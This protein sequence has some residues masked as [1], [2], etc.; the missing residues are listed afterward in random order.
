MAS[1]YG[2]SILNIAAT[3]AANG[4]IGC[5]FDRAST[6]RCQIRTTHDDAEVLY[7]CFPRSEL[8][9]LRG[10]PLHLRGWV[11]RA[12]AITLRTV[13]KTHQN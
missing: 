6:W 10:V 7:D 12:S 11:V 5:F 13:T 3:S 4:G 9:P 8:W 2:G 1:V